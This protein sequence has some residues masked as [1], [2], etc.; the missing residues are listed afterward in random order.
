MGDQVIRQIL[1]AD[2]FQVMTPGG[3]LVK[4]GR[5]QRIQIKPI[6]D[7]LQYIFRAVNRLHRVGEDKF[8]RPLQHAGY[9]RNRF[10]SSPAMEKRV[11]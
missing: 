6:E 2:L 10:I 5:G 1:K 4:V 11:L 8:A 9:F 7:R 3:F